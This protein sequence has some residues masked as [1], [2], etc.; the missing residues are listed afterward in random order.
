MTETEVYKLVI[1]LLL[2]H[3]IFA[4]KS[5]DRIRIQIRFCHSYCAGYFCKKF[6]F[7]SSLFDLTNI[8]QKISK[9]SMS[10]FKFGAQFRTISETDK[11][12]ARVF[13]ISTNKVRLLLRFLLTK[14]FSSSLIIVYSIYRSCI[15]YYVQ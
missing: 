4:F 12:R 7:K 9:M 3:Y 10:E 1:F 6:Y 2:L 8:V 14:F 15:S 11:V 13:I 5:N